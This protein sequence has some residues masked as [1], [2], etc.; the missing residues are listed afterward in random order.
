MDFWKKF[1]MAGEHVPHSFAFE[2]T[3]R[4]VKYLSEIVASSKTVL[5]YRIAGSCTSFIDENYR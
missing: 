3:Y 1:C 2:V 4:N 5:G